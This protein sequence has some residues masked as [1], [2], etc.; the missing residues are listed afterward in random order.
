MGQTASGKS[1]LAEQLSL[2]TG[3]ALVNADAFQV[4]RGMDIGTN[5]PE[6]KGRYHLIDLKEPTEDFGVGEWVTLAQEILWNCYGAGQS[7][8]VVGGTGLYIR[9]LFEE[10]QG[11]A[12]PPAPE[13]RQKLMDE[14][15]QQG[16][17]GLVARLQALDPVL[18]T[19]TDLKNGARVR[20][21]LERLEGQ[22]YSVS[23]S[24]PPYAR[25]KVCLE[26]QWNSQEAVF[27]TR[28]RDMVR[29]G[30]KEEVSRLLEHGVRVN[31]P[32]MRAI[33]Y[34]EVVRLIRGEISEGEW[35]ASVL[36]ETTQYAKRQRTW[37]RSEPNLH[38]FP[39]DGT[40]SPALRQVMSHVDRLLTFG[41]L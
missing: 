20:R 5:K 39:I 27:E 36:L 9:A 17:D 1:W 23:V 30:W 14:E 33:G 16:L 3:A 2:Q 35:I 11:M 21:A 13:L 41:D 18:A 24:L 37:L 31:A 19:K 25:T 15:K 12:G 26:Q 7:V 40:S 10:Y 28:I 4:Y 6:D 32:G 22:T 8:I 38:S 34:R 29:R